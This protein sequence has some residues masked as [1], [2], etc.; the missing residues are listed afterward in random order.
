M[1]LKVLHCVAGL[2]ARDGGPA[3]SVPALANAVGMA[4]AD[5]RVWSRQPAT[6]SLANFKHTKF[7]S[8]TLNANV[9]DDWVPD[10]IHDHGLWLDSNNSVA[11][12]GRK[13]R[14][15]RIVSPRGMLEPWCLRHRQYKKLLAWLLYQHRDLLSCSCLHAT[16]QS[17]VDQFRRLGLKQPIV[18]LPNGVALP[19]P[20]ETASIESE[21]QASETREALFLSRIHPVKGLPN[22]IEAWNN[23]RRPGWRLRIVGSDEDGHK[24][25]IKSLITEHRLNDSVTIEEAVH[26]D[27]KWT[28]LRNADFLVLPSFSE[29]FGIV[30]AEALAAG[31]PVITTTG[32]PWKRVLEK[33]CGWYVAPTADGIAKALTIAMGTTKP[34]LKEM[35][36]RGKEWVREEFSWQDIGQKMLTAYCAVLGAKFK[37]LWGKQCIERKCAA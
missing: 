30:V 4:G 33:Q 7:V 12:L 11:K 31:T 26:S 22:L 35:G 32:T 23:V 21:L 8:G 13:N 25:V 14:I 9:T 15:L 2:N 10:V 27:M 17:E 3:R 24:S 5:V 16:S 6:I 1:S 36:H 28:L 34:E 37:G 20:L 18:Y 19:N 29:N